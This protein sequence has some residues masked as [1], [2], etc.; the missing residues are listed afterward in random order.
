MGDINCLI[1]GA[2]GHALF[3]MFLWDCDVAPPEPTWINVFVGTWTA[4]SQIVYEKAQ[5]GLKRLMTRKLLLE[6]SRNYSV[7][8]E[9]FPGTRL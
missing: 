9:Q 3:K 6:I 2:M 1:D 5:K 8:F 7:I 4:D